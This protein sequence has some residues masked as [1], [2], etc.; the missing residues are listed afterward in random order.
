MAIVLGFHW[1]S[2]IVVGET[3]ALSE[4]LKLTTRITVVIETGDRL[5]LLFGCSSDPFNQRWRSQAYDYIFRSPTF[6]YPVPINVTL[7]F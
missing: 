1:A 7:S 4:D 2:L 5:P 6:H 3:R